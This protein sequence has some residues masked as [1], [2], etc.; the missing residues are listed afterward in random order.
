MGSSWRLFLIGLLIA[1]STSGVLTSS[2]HA[3]ARW[4]VPA[5]ALPPDEVRA[6]NFTNNGNIV[7]KAKPG[8]L[9]ELAI[10]C[11]T[12]TGTGVINGAAATADGVG[13]FR[14]LSFTLANCT[15]NLNCNISEMTVR[16]PTLF[17]PTWKMALSTAGGLYY[18]KV[19][20]LYVRETAGGVGC[21]Q[22][23]TRELTGN[24]ESK[25]NNTTAELEFPTPA[26]AGSNLT[27]G[28]GQEALLI[29]KY[30]I[31]QALEPARAITVGA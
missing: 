7:V 5:G 25:F 10:T 20:N 15:A 28:V 17:P 19:E 30:K 4:H 26:L 2:A 27:L 22:S 11:T 14:S 12:S 8:F 21:T 6:V 1:L 3:V 31:A 24:S 16:F 29:G 18:D 9:E 23:G 13:Y